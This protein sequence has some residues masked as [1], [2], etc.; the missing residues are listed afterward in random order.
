MGS[1]APS[2]VHWH[3]HNI[4]SPTTSKMAYRYGKGPR[5]LHAGVDSAEHKLVEESKISTKRSG[6][7]YFLSSH[8]FPK[9][10]PLELLML[11]SNPFQGTSQH[12]MDSSVV[13][14]GICCK[15]GHRA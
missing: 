14:H 1:A 4:A 13:K 15:L 7:L 8:K 10:T 2:N 3:M 11:V 12:A 9:S 6:E 5:L